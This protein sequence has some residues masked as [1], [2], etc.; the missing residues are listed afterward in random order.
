MNKR[1]K[2][3]KRV[4][5]LENVWR[6]RETCVKHTDVKSTRRTVS[7][8]PGFPGGPGV[9]RAPR[10]SSQKVQ[11]AIS[12]KGNLDLNSA[13]YPESRCAERNVAAVW[14]RH[15]NAMP[16][17]FFLPDGC[18]GISISRRFERVREA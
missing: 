9:P 6:K 14:S 5:K 18:F 1:E 17:S 11:V 2:V 13:H 15:G 10:V 12:G 4:R 3:W 7:H 8:L 16:G